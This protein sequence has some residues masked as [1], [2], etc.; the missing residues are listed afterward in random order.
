MNIITLSIKYFFKSKRDLKNVDVI[1]TIFESLHNCMSELN[2]P[3]FIIFKYH[4]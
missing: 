4:N 3:L 2:F 1:F